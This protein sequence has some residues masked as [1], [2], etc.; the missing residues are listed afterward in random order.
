VSDCILSHPKW[1]IT[2][3]P[4]GNVSGS[5]QAEEQERMNGTKSS[6]SYRETNKQ[7]TKQNNNNNN[8][9]KKQH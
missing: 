1:D 8:N 2:M 7:Q 6:V 9:N 5:C 3:K 4:D